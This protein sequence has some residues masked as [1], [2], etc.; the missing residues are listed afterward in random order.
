M[1]GQG[2]IPTRKPWHPKRRP[3]WSTLT[4]DNR[5]V[6]LH[7]VERL[8]GDPDQSRRQN[9]GFYLIEWLV[10]LTSASIPALTAA[11]KPAAVVGVIGATVT[12]LVSVRQL[13]HS[14]ENWI[15]YAATVVAL[16]GELVAWHVAGDPYTD[17]T[18]ADAMLA[19]RVEEVVRRETAQWRALRDGG[20]RP[21]DTSEG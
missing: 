2:P 11:G 3:W 21:D 7:V 18:K 8:R 5:P 13:L 16:E 4:R 9:T 1:A 14:R 15:R 17:E 6:P 12:G 19:T 10:I 20:L